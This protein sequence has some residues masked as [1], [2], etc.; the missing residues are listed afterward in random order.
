MLQAKMPPDSVP[1]PQ[2]GPIL[3]TGSHRSGS[4]W[5]GNV[6][7]LAA[8]S[9]YV[10]EPFN[11]KTRRGIC[12]ARFPDDFTYVTRETEGP[13]VGPLGDTLRWRY[14]YAAEIPDLRTPRDVAR[15]VR[16]G[17]YFK[18][19]QLQGARLVMK[20][21]IALFSAEWLSER[22]DMPVVT[23]I[24]HPAAFVASLI[25]AGWTRFHFSKLLVQERLMEERLAP[26]RAEIAAAAAELPD[27]VGVGILLWRLMHH[28]IRQLRDDHPDWICVR[29]EDLTADPV[30]SFRDIYGRLGLAFAPD[31]PE[32]IANL[33]EQS[34]G[35]AAFSLFGSRRRVNRNSKDVAKLF[36][37]RL[38]EED[39]RRISDQAGDVWPDFYTQDEW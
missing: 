19:R 28:H 39:I 24:R 38:S 18:T 22:F 6:L 27:D 12:A 29:P 35:L 23:I 16:D 5:V 8:G 17:A 30:A 10:H 13:Y 37:K 9:G 1:C 14:A 2:S 4:T 21:P 33:S 20:D 25:A 31:T 36:R 15:M 32:R 26:Y 11:V 34:G 3:V 7:S